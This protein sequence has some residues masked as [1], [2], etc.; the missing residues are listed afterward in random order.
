MKSQAKSKMIYL[1]QAATSFPK[2]KEVI[3]G[4]VRCLERCGNAGRGGHKASLES[5]KE[6]YDCRCAICDFFHYQ[7][8]ENVIFTYNA[9]YAL[10]TVICA[11]Y[12]EG[13]HVLISD[14]EH[15]A[16]YRPVLALASE[17][18]ITYSVF[19]HKGNVI[20]NIRAQIR[21]N[22]DM[23]ICTQSSNVTGF[24]LPL[25]EIGALSKSK[26]IKLIIDASQGAGHIETDLTSQYFTAYCAPAH[27]ALYGIQGC[28]FA[29][30]NQNGELM[31]EFIRG[32]T[33]SDPFSATMPAEIPEHF[34]AG[35]LATPCICGLRH[36]IEYLQKHKD[37]LDYTHYLA[38]RL[39]EILQENA[40]IHIVSE[41]GNKSFIISFTCPEQDELSQALADKNICIRGGFHCAPLAHTSIGTQNTGCIRAS[42]GLFTSKKDIETFGHFVSQWVNGSYR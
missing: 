15:N 41:K 23:L 17:G 1:D 39:E 38:K 40:N 28:G 36:G 12:K 3:V 42:L 19:S 30:I 33:G 35:T 20:E 27:K 4:V 29:I 6:I 22:T 13:S 5:A 34:E 24:A 8:P 21:D 18:K 9:T 32:G 31:R 11:L 16:V 25:K 14:L 2:P 26:K 7:A 37:E 10:N